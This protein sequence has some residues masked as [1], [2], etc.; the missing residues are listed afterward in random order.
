MLLFEKDL[1]GKSWNVCCKE[2]GI[3][4]DDFY[5]EIVNIIWYI[6]IYNI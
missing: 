4:T 5:H 2:N 6:Y 3:E 1:S